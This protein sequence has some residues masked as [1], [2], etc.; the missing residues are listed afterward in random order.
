MSLKVIDESGNLTK[1]QMMAINKFVK[2]LKFEAIINKAS[3][4]L[5]MCGVDFSEENFFKTKAYKDFIEKNKRG[6]KCR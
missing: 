5:L 1:E 6:G 2:D 3:F 4:E